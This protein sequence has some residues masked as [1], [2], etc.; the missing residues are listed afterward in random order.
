MEW[1]KDHAWETWTALAILL[2]LA[3]LLSLDLVL[4]M[5]AVGAGVGVLTAL[6][7]LP[8][9]AQIL[10]AVGAA[11]AMLLFVRPG[12]VKRLHSGPEL[13]LGHDALVGRQGVVVSEVSADAGQIKIGGELWTARPY[14]ETVTIHEG[15]RVDVF[16]I[17][18]ATAYV[19]PVPA[20]ESDND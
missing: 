1:F 19:H 20:I 2:A 7:G 14:D 13:R 4:L 3:E 6:I 18:G 5:L 11:T 17:K 9:A 15:A 12:I 16:Q 8:V 10:A